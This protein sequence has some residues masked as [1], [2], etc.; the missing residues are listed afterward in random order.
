M[1]IDILSIP[2]MYADPERTIYG[3]AYD[4]ME[5]NALRIIDN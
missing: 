3:A 5:S 4:V 2:A 1:A